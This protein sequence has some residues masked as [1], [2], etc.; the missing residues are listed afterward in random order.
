VVP[1]F[2]EAPPHRRTRS[3]SQQERNRKSGSKGG[4]KVTEGQI[5][6]MVVKYLIQ[7]RSLNENK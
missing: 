3:R 5:S 7:L 6:D 4:N 2:A 1:R